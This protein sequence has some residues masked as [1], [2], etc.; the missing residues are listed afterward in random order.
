ML[1]YIKIPKGQKNI[2]P[3]GDFT[4]TNADNNSLI[5]V[6]VSLTITVPAN[7]K[8]DFYCKVK[9]FEGASVYVNYEDGANVSASE[10]FFIESGQTF[11]IMGNGLVDNANF[12]VIRYRPPAD[13]DWYM[14]FECDHPSVVTSRIEFADYKFRIMRGAELI[15]E[16][17]DSI[18]GVFSHNVDNPNGDL[19]QIYFNRNKLINDIY[20]WSQA[21]VMHWDD[22]DFSTYTGDGIKML[23]FK[24]MTAF[25][26]MLN[27]PN[28]VLDLNFSDYV[29]KDEALYILEN[30]NG[31]TI[32]ASGNIVSPSYDKVVIDGKLLRVF[33]GSNAIGKLHSLELKNNPNLERFTWFQNYFARLI[34]GLTIENC[35]NIN[36]LD[37]R[38]YQNSEGYQINIDQILIDRDNSGVLNGTLIFSPD[39]VFTA[40]SDAARANLAANGWD[41]QFNVI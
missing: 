6:N 14:H 29:D 24:S 37:V 2:F 5:R 31:D 36:Y 4:L 8:P 11:T 21:D 16:S 9:V 1:N 20:Y 40:A 15:Y 3:E 18:N 23:N 19:L 12:E 39:F 27:Q 28:I 26:K 13:R 22:I 17:P 38:N 41:L 32:K 30:F 34:T 25:I 33:D 7:L 10:G 35:P